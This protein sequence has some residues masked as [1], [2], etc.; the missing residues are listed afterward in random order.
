MPL[1]TFLNTESIQV[2]VEKDIADSRSASFEQD[3]LAF[4]DIMTALGYA[5]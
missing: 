2:S 3:T 4:V 1:H 5:V